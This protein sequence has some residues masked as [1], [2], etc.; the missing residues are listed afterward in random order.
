[1]GLV[2]DL[3]SYNKLNHLQ[4][5]V[6]GFSLVLVSRVTVKRPSSFKVKPKKE[7]EMKELNPSQMRNLFGGTGA[8]I[9][10]PG[11]PPP[12]ENQG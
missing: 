11:E 3:P 6:G 2:L 5:R 8:D 10:R 4:T 9:P 7:T 1:M 12:V